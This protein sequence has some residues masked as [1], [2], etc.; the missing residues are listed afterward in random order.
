MKR[1][2]IPFVL[3]AFAACDDSTTTVVRKP[4]DA[5]PTV[6]S[7]VCDLANCP[8]PSAQGA[9]AC[10]TPDAKC[11][12]DPTGVGL[13]CIP[14]AAE[15]GTCKVDEC[16][17]PPSRFG[18]ACCTPLA[19]CGFD[20][21]SN[22]I[23]C[24]PAAFELPAV[25]AA[26]PTACLASCPLTDGGP[27]PCCQANGQCGVDSLGIGLCFPPPPPVCDPAK[28]PAN[29][30]GVKG[31]CTL[32]NSCGYD[33][34]GNGLCFPPPVEGKC[35][36]AK[37]PSDGK[38]RACC[39]P[40][41]QCGV[42]SLNLGVCFPPPFKL[43]DAGPPPPVNPNPPDDPS[44]T[45]EC[46]SFMGVFGPT[47]GCCSPYGVCGTF[48]NNQCNVAPGTPIQVPGQPFHDAGS[49]VLRCTVPH[50]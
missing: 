21:F 30:A 32:A 22:G 41:G 27:K 16:P 35:D 2:L 46:P 47:W 34:F 5:G 6:T 33:Y 43:P 10:C 7:G 17:A 50:P 29:D 19:Q 39:Q 3:L 11:G 20:P 25:D 14:A 23:F 37:C 38:M 42:D 9:I 45:G 15:P 48:A 12:T 8:K 1:F 40:N 13:G 28:C 18:K 44:I 26:A 24:F 49:S 36:L 31:C 4:A